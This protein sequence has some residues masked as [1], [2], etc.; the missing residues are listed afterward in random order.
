MVL[1]VLIWGNMVLGSVLVLGF[2][3]DGSIQKEVRSH[4]GAKSGLV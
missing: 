2:K 1:L 4:S 3:L